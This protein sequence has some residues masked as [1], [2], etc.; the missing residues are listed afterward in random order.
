[1][2]EAELERLEHISL[3]E[4]MTENQI[5]SVK[6]VMTTRFFEKG[7]TIISEGE[8]GDELF[9]LLNGSI[10]I[11]KRMTLQSSTGRDQRDKSL[12]QLK[13]S[14]HVFF[15]EMSLLRNLER[16]ATVRALTETRLGVLTT[17]QVM[18]IADEDPQF[19]YLLF[20]NIGRTL[21]DHLRRANKDILKLT[22]ALCLALESR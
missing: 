15:G 20:Y 8:T 11:S 19:G 17:D 6:Q 2:R 3:F 22:T 18:K 14:D 5:E 12:I 9:V 16:S 4:G 10:A 13:D 7:D 1:M 21:A